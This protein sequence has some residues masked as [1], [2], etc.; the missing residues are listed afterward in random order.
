[1]LP[2]ATIAG[3]P[4]NL[5]TMNTQVSNF[6]EAS[7]FQQLSSCIKDTTLTLNMV[8][9][10][11][12]WVLW[13]KRKYVFELQVQADLLNYAD[14][15]IPPEKEIPLFLRIFL[16]QSPNVGFCHPLLDSVHWDSYY[17]PPVSANEFRYVEGTALRTLETDPSIGNV[18]FRTAW[19]ADKLV[20]EDTASLVY[21]GGVN[22]TTMAWDNMGDDRYFMVAHATLEMKN[23]NGET[24]R[25]DMSNALP[26]QPLAVLDEPYISQVDSAGKIFA[27]VLIGL[28]GLVTLAMFCF[29]S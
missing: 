28:A 2:D 26:G 19:I 18:T 10:T 6:P 9:Q 1:M 29:I 11:K 14:L 7:N 4:N 5:I 21:K 17:D 22:M 23:G 13:K 8:N 27:G 20:R 16:C 15:V 24:V 25:L 3:D 12:N